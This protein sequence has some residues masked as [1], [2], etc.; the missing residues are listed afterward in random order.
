M[1]ERT[2]ESRIARVPVAFDP[3]RGA[4]VRDAFGADGA[5]GDLLSGM[6]GSSPYLAGLV[7]REGE[8]LRSALAG[9][10]EAAFGEVLAGTAALGGAET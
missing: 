3:A 4:E 6:G 7:E 5:L 9:E 10:P 1:T 2:F 8:W